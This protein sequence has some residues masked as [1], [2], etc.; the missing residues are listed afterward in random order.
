[1]KTST[2][3]KEHGIQKTGLMQLDDSNFTGDLILLFFTHQRVQVMKNSVAEAFAAVGL[4]T[5]RRK[6]KFLKQNTV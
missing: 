4:N 5:Y 6:S 1:M 3:E 2:F